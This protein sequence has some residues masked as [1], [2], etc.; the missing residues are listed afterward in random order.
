MTADST[1]AGKPALLPAG[2][3]LP[4]LLI[5]AGSDS[6]GGAG[7]QADVKTAL[8]L[9]VDGYAAITALTVQNTL[10]VHGVWE[11]PQPALMAQ[12][13]AVLATGVVAVKTGMLHSAM[14]IDTVIGRIGAVVRAGLPLVVD[15]V[16]VAKGGHRLLR[17]DAIAALTTRMLPLATIVT[18]NLPEAEVLTGRPIAAVDDMIAAGRSLI[19]MGARSALIKGGHMSGDMLS[20]ILVIAGATERDPVTV[21][22]F[23]GPRIDSRHTHGTGC[24]MA[25]AIAAGLA[26]GRGTGDAVAIARS[27]VRQAMLAAPGLGHGH[28]PLRHDWNRRSV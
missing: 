17:E 21:T 1:I 4:R 18:P 14:V 5:I 12:I 19:G 20:D 22:R 11:V 27:Y 9:G 13:D 26:R 3:H 10:G 2:R 24:T 25:S 7:I 28:G 16:M 15:P 23:D 6:G 8:A